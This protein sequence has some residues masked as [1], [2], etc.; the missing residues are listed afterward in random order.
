MSECTLCEA[1]YRAINEERKA[2]RALTGILS[3]ARRCRVAH[4]RMYKTVCICYVC[5]SVR[6]FEETVGLKEQA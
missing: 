2:M 4:E 1:A 6:E 3:A 5:E